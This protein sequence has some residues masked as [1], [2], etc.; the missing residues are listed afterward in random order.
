MLRFVRAAVGALA[1]AATGLLAAGAIDL[2]APALARPHGVWAALGAV[3]GLAAA[4]RGA[5]RGRG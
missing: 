3:A 4:V 1:G 5:R 2:V